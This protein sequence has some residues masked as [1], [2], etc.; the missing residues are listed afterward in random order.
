[1]HVFLVFTLLIS[2][3]PGRKQDSI[4]F[5]FERLVVPGKTGCRAKCKSCSKDMQGLV[6]RMKQHHQLCSSEDTQD[7]QD[8]SVP[9]CITPASPRPASIKRSAS[10][11]RSPHLKRQKLDNFVVQTSAHDKAAFDIQVARYLYATNSAFSHT[12]HKEFIKLVNML[13]PG[14]NPPSRFD[15][16]N[17]LLDQVHNTMESDCRDKLEG[18]TCSMS[19][20]GWSNV[21]NEPIE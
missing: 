18:Q 13:H 3:M 16:A 7:T 6:T 1:M 5:Y 19:L 12:E 11:P 15:V 14:Y 21:H 10:P 8:T 9:P 4:W 20:D 2:N 17:K